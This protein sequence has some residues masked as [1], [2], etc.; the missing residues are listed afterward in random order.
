M[1]EQAFTTKDALHDLVERQTMQLDVVASWE[2]LCS[3]YEAM[4]FTDE[5]SDVARLEEF[6]WII[7]QTNKFLTRIRSL[8]M[9]S[10]NPE[11]MLKILED[12]Q[13]PSG[14]TN[15]TERKMVAYQK[16]KQMWI[17]A[18]MKQIM[19]V[20]IMTKEKEEQDAYSEYEY[21]GE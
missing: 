16:L 1:N 11:G 15:L 19:D 2:S 13:F 10:K 8:L 20:A 4:K 7:G 6:K 18:T 9:A 17:A 12:S 21:D 5:L 14:K 3:T